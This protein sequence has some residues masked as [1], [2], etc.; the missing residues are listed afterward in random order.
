MLSKVSERG[1]KESTIPLFIGPESSS[2]IVESLT[3]FLM[4]A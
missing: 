1:T 4:A 2:S 3:G